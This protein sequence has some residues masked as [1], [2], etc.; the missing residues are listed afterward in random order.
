MRFW[1]VCCCVFGVDGGWWKF[2]DYPPLFPS[3]NKPIYVV[4]SACIDERIPRLLVVSSGA[5]SRPD[6]LGYKVNEYK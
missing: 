4:H 5:V 6:S 1:G 2:G 3:S